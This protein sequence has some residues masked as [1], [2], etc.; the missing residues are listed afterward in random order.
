MAN[1]QQPAMGRYARI[2]L[3]RWLKRAFLFQKDSLRLLQLF[4]QEVIPEHDIVEIR[5]DNVEYVALMEDSKDVR[6]DVECYDKDGTRFVCEVQVSPQHHFYERA[7][8]N[9]TLAIQKQKRQGESDYD[10]PTV[11]FIG[12]MDF[13]MHEDSGRVDFRYT[14]RENLTGELMT[15]RIQYVFLEIPN[16]LQRA[17]TPEASVLDNVCYA[18]HMMEHL[19]ERPAQLK[20]E[21]FKLLFDSA[22]LSKFT[23]EERARYQLDMTTERDIHNQ[24]VF[25]RDKGR[26][27]GLAEGRAEGAR[28]Q[29]IQT[30]R[31]LLKLDVPVEIIAQGTGLSTEEVVALR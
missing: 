19:T 20:Q 3:D 29:A 12:L 1:R 14:L 13:S 26:S 21:I 10:F 4:I 22:E 5:T 30:A 28:E 7:V 17:L 15:P 8:Y 2:L 6:V 18:L 24:I 27:E 9:S 31:N 16:A 25:A 23:A 11:Y